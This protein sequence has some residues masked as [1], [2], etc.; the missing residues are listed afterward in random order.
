MSI[1]DTFKKV[2][3][4]IAARQEEAERQARREQPVREAEGD[5]PLF[6]CRVCG[7]ESAD[8]T[9]C[10]ECLADTMEPVPKRTPTPPL[11]SKP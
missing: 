10:P 3:D 2:V 8:R 11:H 9:Y 5:P 7:T 4:P 1:I 6:R